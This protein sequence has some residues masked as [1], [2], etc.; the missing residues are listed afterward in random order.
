MKRCYKLRLRCRSLA[1]T[2]DLSI[3]GS[4]TNW[5]EIIHVLR[6]SVLY[7]HLIVEAAVHV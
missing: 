4:K 2:V 5:V 1:T 3:K 6:R 7:S